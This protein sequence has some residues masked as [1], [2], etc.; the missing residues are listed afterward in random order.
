MKTNKCGSQEQ[1]TKRMAS[2]V[3]KKQFYIKKGQKK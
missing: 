1:K 2:T 3:A